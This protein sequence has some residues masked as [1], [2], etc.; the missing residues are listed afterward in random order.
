M[1]KAVVIVA[2]LAGGLWATQAFAQSAGENWRLC[3]GRTGSVEERIASCDRLIATARSGTD[4]SDAYSNRGAYRK[5]LGQL[6]LALADYTQAIAIDPSNM[7]AHVNRATILERR[8]Q[9]ELAR[10]DYIAITRFKP[11]IAE[12]FL[13]RG[14]AFQRLGDQK[15][16]LDD[17]DRAVKESPSIPATRSQSLRQR[18]EVL[19]RMGNLGPALTDLTQAAAVDPKDP[20]IFL[21]LGQTNQA[22]NRFQP[23]IEAFTHAIELNPELDEAWWGRCVS[24]G[25]L[26]EALE[27]AL[28]D[29]NHAISR[30]PPKKEPFIGRALI[31]YRLNRFAEAEGDAD[32][33]LQANP[34]NAPALYLRAL[35]KQGRKL[36]G[37]A[38]LADAKALS[39]GVERLFVA[40]G[41]KP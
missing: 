8:G 34:K 7:M 30:S 10:E 3:A 32:R 28:D 40:M 11:R 22:L 16:A 39:P 31:Y 2:M 24:E 14:Q 26:G 1:I 25:Q 33:I 41:F 36:D 23:A 29:C 15:A 35:S 5:A 21:H 13:S 38:D 12:E 4:L 27:R 17:F 18:G 19:Q 37:D 20:E 6:D 9:S